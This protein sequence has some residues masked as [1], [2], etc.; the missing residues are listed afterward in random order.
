MIGRG[1]CM[2]LDMRVGVMGTVFCGPDV[3]LACKG[4]CKCVSVCCDSVKAT[5]LPS[6]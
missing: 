5:H 2:L 3:R 6:W 4:Y 1:T